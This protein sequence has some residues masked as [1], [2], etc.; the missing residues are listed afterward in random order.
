MTIDLR[1]LKSSTKF[2]LVLGTIFVFAGVGTVAFV[3][4]QMRFQAIREAEQKVGII[5]DRNLAT[6]AYFTHQVKPALLEVTG[7][8]ATENYFEPV[9]MSSTY[10]VREID[11][12]FRSLMD[13]NYYYK[14]CAVN[15]R[16]PENEADA[17]EKEFIDRLNLHPELTRLST[18]RHMEDGPYFVALRRGETMESSCLRCHSVPEKAPGDLVRT[19]GPERSFNRKVGEVV[20]AISIR[21]PLAEPYARAEGM[22]LKLSGLFVTVLI[23]LFGTLKWLASRLFLEPL[24]ALQEQAV[25]IVSHNSSL[26]EQIPL[27]SGKELRGLTSA[28]NVMSLSLEQSLKGLEDRV[29]ERTSELTKANHRLNEEIEVRKKVEETQEKLV[30]DLKAA[31]GKVRTLSG[32]LPICASC[33]KIRDDKGYWN[34]IETYI[35]TH[36]DADFSHCI[37]PE[38]ANK[39][40]PGYYSQD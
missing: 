22:T 29:Q 8:L 40:Y 5:L 33:K 34:K 6:H 37:C 27:P 10:A 31:L 11:R 18:V 16:N 17:F 25:R 4:R 24:S 19:Y 15:A 12:Y 38:C 9:W 35:R 28:F 21:V 3:N 14:E 32:L 7:F 20:S 30:S 39:L 23:L 13:A 2:F 26:G 1:G 36:S